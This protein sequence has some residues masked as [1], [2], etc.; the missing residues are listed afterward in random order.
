MI[1]ASDGRHVT[2]GRHRRPTEAELV[3]AAEALETERLAGWF[4]RMR[5]TYYGEG[6]PTLDRLRLLTG[7]R[8]DWSRA[9]S[10]FRSLRSQANT[11][12]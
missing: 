4:V 8:G 7:R 11:Q 10:L 9:V 2:L 5:G 12:S 1:L 3:R 6:E